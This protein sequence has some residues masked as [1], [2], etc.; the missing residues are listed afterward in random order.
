MKIRISKTAIIG[1]IATILGL[2]A[3][4]ILMIVIGNDPFAGY[5]YLFS[6]GLMNIERIGNTLATAAPLVFSGLAVAFAFN[7]GLFNIGAS[8]QMLLGGLCATAIGLTLNLP[9]PL[10]LSLMLL[11]AMIGGGLWAVIPGYLKAK[12]NVHEV[13]STIMMNWIAYWVIYY[14]VPAYFKGPYL[15]TESAKIPQSASLKVEWLTSMFNGSYIN[16]G[17]FLAI[18]AVIIVSIILNKTILGFELK[19]AGFNRYAAEYA[20]MSVNLNIMLSM[21]ISGILAGAG[22][23]ALYVGYASNIQIGVLPSQGF[24]GIAISLLGGN[25]PVGVFVASLFFG[26]LH[27]G[28]GFMNA[29]TNIPPA[30]GDTII[31]IIIYFA[32]TSV[33]IDRIIYSGRFKIKGRA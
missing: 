4:G 7:T 19:A 33:L 2:F 12:F 26:V 24:D 6:G 32:A 25:T 18:L 31:A 16:L 5:L 9:K 15:E 8:G 17:I 1:I 27:S 29:M 10:L 11:A 13:V 14:V 22:G 28:K 20:G 3:G 30:I 21:V 23:A